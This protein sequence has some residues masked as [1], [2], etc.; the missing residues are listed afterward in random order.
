[1]NPLPVMGGYTPADLQNLGMPRLY[2]KLLRRH[3]AAKAAPANLNAEPET[4]TASTGTLTPTNL[5]PEPGTGN[6]EP[7]LN[8]RPVKVPRPRSKIA[9]LPAELQQNLNAMLADGRPYRSIINW[10][11][12]GGHPGF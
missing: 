12:Q 10:L 8:G 3:A 2:F 7:N 1:M 9:K 5:D 11:S 6:S 4:L